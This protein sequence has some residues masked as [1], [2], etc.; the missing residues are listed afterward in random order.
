M[1]LGFSIFLAIA[2][3][4][5]YRA[6]C[7]DGREAESADG[8][9]AGWS[10][11]GRGQTPERSADISNFYSQLREENPTGTTKVSVWWVPWGFKCY[12]G[13]LSTLPPHRI[14]G[15]TTA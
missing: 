7:A 3:S 12:Q 13:T 4:R 2:M 9:E 15:K 1:T 5:P 14:E 10:M 8:K 6:E 11:L